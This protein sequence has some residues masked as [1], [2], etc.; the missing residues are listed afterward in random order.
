[1]IRRPLYA[2]TSEPDGYLNDSGL[3]P[4][5]RKLFGDH[6]TEL[7]LKEAEAKIIECD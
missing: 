4:G 1:M 2:A 3:A 7:G 6:P 5:P